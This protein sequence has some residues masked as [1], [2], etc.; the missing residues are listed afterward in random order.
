MRMIGDAAKESLEKARKAAEKRRKRREKMEKQK[1][2]SKKKESGDGKPE[3]G[4]E[5]ELFERYQG[6][7]EELEGMEEEL[8][9]GLSQKRKINLLEITEK[10]NKYKFYRDSK[11]AI[12]LDFVITMYN[13]V[14]LSRFRKA[15]NDGYAWLKANP[16]RTK[17]NYRRFIMNWAKN[18][19]KNV[20]IN[21]VKKS[22]ENY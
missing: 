10:C 16:N 12:D 11:P 18:Q 22:E 14:G 2:E 5:K 1:P 15:L 17:K 7:I 8:W 21:I 3:T 4:K 9:Q 6:Q 20:N 13:S 19:G